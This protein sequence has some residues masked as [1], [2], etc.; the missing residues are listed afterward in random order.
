M[1]LPAKF[2]GRARRFFFVLHLWTGL[3]LGVWL[4]LI[5]LTGSLL[6]WMPEL[7]TIEAQSR[8]PKA[9]GEDKMTLSGALAAFKTRYPDLAAKELSSVQMPTGRYPYYVVFRRVEGQINVIMADP[10]SGRVFPMYRLKDLQMGK[11]IEF[12][13]SLLFGIPG[14]LGNGVLSFFA[15]LLLSSGLWLW[16]PSNWRQF[17]ARISVKNGGSLSRR[18]RDWHN[19]LG[20]YLYSI[21]FVTTLTAV[22]LVVNH[23]TR[24]GLEK[25]VDKRAGAVEAEYQAVPNGARLGVD[26]LV[27]LAQK[28][29]PDAP[30]DGVRL[31]LE[32]DAPFQSRHLRPSGFLNSSVVSID[33]YSG[34][35]L[36]VE[37]DRDGTPGHKTLTLVQDL[38]FGTF[39]G[40]LTK[41][42]YTLAGILPLGLFITGVMMWRKRLKNQ[43]K[44][45]VQNAGEERRAE[46]VEA[47]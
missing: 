17:K 12:H 10:V 8:Y 11:V 16:W 29:V 37:H 43:K 34:K 41:W 31:P 9:P 22:L 5:G 13:T 46:T 14:L 36:G 3:S 26:E 24:G 44:G 28:A 2:S 25:A 21:L 19:V 4:S 7:V 30:I 38:H 47:A 35:T 18:V 6:A 32:A 27:L 40:A 23:A 42:L 39:G 1:A 33:P 45:R 15:L 20:I